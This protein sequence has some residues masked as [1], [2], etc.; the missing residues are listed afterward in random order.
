[1]KKTGLIWIWVT[2]LV[3]VLDRVSKMLASS[4]LPSDHVVHVFPS[5]NLTLAHN[6]GAAFSFLAGAG[7]WQG[8]LFGGIA[9]LISLL[10]VVWLWRSPRRRVLLG[11]AL[12]LVLGGALGNLW[13]RV[14]YG[15][16]IDFLDFYFGQWH[17]AA[18]NVADSAICIGAALLIWDVFTHREGANT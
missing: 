10:I 1:M 6:T 9:V 13:D 4:L 5:F 17:F 7:G 15:Y 11:I 3:V 12:A 2:V 14:S 18:F 16:V 8:V